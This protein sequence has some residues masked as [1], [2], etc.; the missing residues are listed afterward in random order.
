MTIHIVNTF[1]LVFNLMKGMAMDIEQRIVQLD[2]ENRKLKKLIIGLFL[3]SVLMIVTSIMTPK[4]NIAS[5][6]QEYIQTNEVIQARRFEIVNSMGTPVLTIGSKLDDQGYICTT[7]SL[8]IL[9][10]NNRGEVTISASE[11]G[12]KILMSDHEGRSTVALSTG[13]DGGQIEI[14]N[15][16]QKESV[17]LWSGEYGGRMVVFDE[18]GKKATIIGTG[19]YGGVIETLDANEK[20]VATMGVGEYGGRS[21]ILNS[22]GKMVAS[23]GAWKTG[24]ANH[25]N[26][27][28]SNGGVQIGVT[29]DGGNIIIKNKTGEPKCSM[30]VDEY[31]SGQ[32]GVFSRDG[33]GQIFSPLR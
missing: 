13:R 27:N 5:E 29:E 9:N 6:K 2:H 20:T 8:G 26:S 1:P 33:K 30:I 19:V 7:N 10:D 31:G 18:D 22:D 17:M 14:V 23:I 4:I 21:D 11:Y 3:F 28:D 25:V 32:I 16:N 15:V 12:S 24:G